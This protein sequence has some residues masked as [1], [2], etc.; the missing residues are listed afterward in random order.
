MSEQ[1]DNTKSTPAAASPEFS[2]M[3][4]MSPPKLRKLIEGLRALPNVSDL[5]VINAISELDRIATTFEGFDLL[6]KKLIEGMAASVEDIFDNGCECENCVA[7]RAERA[8]DMQG[9]A[10]TAKH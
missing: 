10:G 2:P 4:E 7:A 9:S 6:R 1:D 8:K 3:I 5:A